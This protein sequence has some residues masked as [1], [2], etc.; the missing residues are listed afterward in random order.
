MLIQKRYSVQ[1]E[2]S[3][4]QIVCRFSEYQLTSNRKFEYG[5]TRRKLAKLKMLF[6]GVLGNSARVRCKALL[7][8]RDEIKTAMS[9]VLSVTIIRYLAGKPR[10]DNTRPP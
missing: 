10:A 5:R 1:S 4:L 3:Q 2:C 6:C 7:R 8:R 9:L